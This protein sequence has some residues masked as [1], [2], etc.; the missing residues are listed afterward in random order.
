MSVFSLIWFL[1]IGLAAG[2]LAGKIMKTG[3][4]GIVQNLVV[5]VIGALIGGIAMGVINTVLASVIGQLLA[6]TLGAMLLIFLLR[7]FR[8]Y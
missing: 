6:A 1:L 2:W 7:K 4:R 3:H 5:G 8:K